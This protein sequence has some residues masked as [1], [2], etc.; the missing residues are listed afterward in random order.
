MAPWRSWKTRA[1]WPRFRW[2]P[3]A[4]ARSRIVH[5][6]MCSLHLDPSRHEPEQIVIQSLFADGFIAYDVSDPSAPTSMM[7]TR[8]ALD[9]E[10]ACVTARNRPLG[11]MSIA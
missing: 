5:T 4:A 8:S 10:V 7:F 2:E 6:E 11:E 3:G 9:A 1:C